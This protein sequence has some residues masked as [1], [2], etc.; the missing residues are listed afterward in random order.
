MKSE[1]CCWQ[2]DVCIFSLL[3]K[4]TKSKDT[5][6]P[7]IISFLGKVWRCWG[8]AKF[9]SCFTSCV[10]LRVYILNSL[11]YLELKRNIIAPEGFLENVPWHEDHHLTLITLKYLDCIRRCPIRAM[12]FSSPSTLISVLKFFSGCRGKKHKDYDYSSSCLSLMLS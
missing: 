10:Y 4:R 7:F 6:F 9:A 8:M 2:M 5:F 3:S 12:A 11:P 1:T